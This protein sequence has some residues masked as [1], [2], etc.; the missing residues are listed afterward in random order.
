MGS[1]KLL[2]D[3]T[4]LISLTIEL[5]KESKKTHFVFEKK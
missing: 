4:S 5:K 1:P 2:R 3:Y